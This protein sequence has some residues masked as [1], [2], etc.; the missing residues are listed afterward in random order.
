MPYI[1]RDLDRGNYLKLDDISSSFNGSTTTFNLTAAGKAFF[2]GSSFSI[3]VVLSGVIQEPNAAYQ[4]NNSQIT[5]ASAPAS[6]AEFYCIVLGVALGANVPGNGTI[7]GTKLA[8]GFNYDGYFYLDDT[9]NRVGVGTATPAKPLHVVGEGQFDSVRVLGDLTVDGTTTTLDTVV[10]EVD[11]LEVGANNN[12]VGLA[13]TQ[14]G[15]GDAAHFIGGNVGIGTDNPLNTLHVKGPTGGVSA[16]F[17]D[18]VNATVFV[19]HPS[20]GKSKIADAGGNYGF[21]FDT[22]SVNILSGGSEKVRITSDGKVGIGT[23]N[24]SNTLA[25]N[26]PSNEATVSLLNAGVK[27]AALSSSNNFGSILYSYESEPLIFSVSTGQAF[28]EKVRVT[29]AGAVGIGSALPQSQ[30]EVFGSSPVI[31]SKHSTSQA[32]TQIN[33]NGTDG[34]VDWSTG[35]L[36]FRGASN[37]ERLRINSAGEVGIGNTS[38]ESYGSDGRNLVIGNSSSNA[39]TGITLVSGSGGYSTLYFADGTSGTALYSGTIVYNH[40]DNRMDF[41]TNGVRR[42]RI[43][44]S[45]SIITGSDAV[46]ETIG[47][48]AAHIQSNANLSILRRG[49]VSA[50]PYLNLG[51]SRNSTPGNFTVVQDNDYI[52]SIGFCADD[53]TDINHPVAYIHGRVNGTPGAN[54][55]P[56][57]LTFAT[58]PDGGTQ[59]L[60]RLRIDASGK[61]GVG[62]AP[63]SWDSSSTSTVLQVKNSHL[64]DYNGAQLDVG[65]NYYYDGSNYKYTTTGHAGRMTFHKS[66]GTIRFWTLGTGSA[67]ANA[68]L[69]ERLRIATTGNI[70]LNETVPYY[71]LHMVFSNAA[72]SFSGGSSGQWGGDGIRIENTNTTAGSMSLVHYRN[73]DA[74]WHVGSKYVA[75]NNSSFIFSCEGSTPLVQIDNEGR[76]KIGDIANPEASQ[77]DCPVYIDMHSDITAFNT[78]EGAANSGF[79][80]LE[81]TGS[82]NSRYHGIELRNRNSGDIRIMN[83]DVSTSDRGDLVFAMPDGGANTGLH[84]KT[85]FNSL[86][87]SL[88]IAGKNGA[89]LANSGTEHVDV[90]IAT[91]TLLTDV[92]TGAGSETAGLIRFEDK[93]ANNGRYHG[94]EIR[95]RNSGDIRILNLDEGTTN[96]ASMVLAV[97]DGSTVVEAMK[98]HSAGYITTPLQPSFSAYKDGHIY[99]TSNTRSV[100]KP[101][102]QI[103]DTHSDFNH[104]TGVF[105]APVSGTYFFYISVMQ[106]RQDNGDF[107][108]GLHINGSSNPHLNSNDLPD[109]NTTTFQQTTVNGVVNL[110]ANDT[111]DFRLYNS[112]QTSSYL[113]TSRYTHCGGFLIG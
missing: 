27:K 68:T 51:K 60:E 98:L 109:H 87:S 22:A 53:G 9:N 32:Y 67:N 59:P 35:G 93:G 44:S 38:P 7:D 28:S 34:Y 1:G 29:S 73:Y 5:F 100:I 64:F 26:A 80:R 76:V 94:L 15:S 83:L 8:G 75:Q 2:P 99:P 79:V 88:Q 16:R 92:N 45:G 86:K 19:S 18:A 17:T 36:I 47:G 104:T 110:S 50:G 102:I 84:F 30:F 23:A 111:L 63:A 56:G 46:S 11:R 90:Y 41:W 101:W 89:T 96:K 49:N 74:D 6:G 103:H 31:R 21:E 108:I 55:V 3:L 52:G 81:E 112:S 37:A 107:Q 97:D 65:H 20:A 82:N 40:S 42:L 66:D 62:G 85:R 70:G 71:K 4:I 54:D 13:V 39:A 95:N 24:P 14:S 106:H 69:S 43:D 61:I 33:H 105:T 57:M 72:T 78:A 58:T 77:C 10:T 91:K 48:G 113:Y 12:T 25:I